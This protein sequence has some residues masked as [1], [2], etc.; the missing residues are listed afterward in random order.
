MGM[1]EQNESMAQQTAE[2]KKRGKRPV[3]GL[4]P[5]YDEFKDSYWMLP[6][7]MI[8]LEESGAIPVMMPLTADEEAVR[9]LAEQ[10]DG[11][12]LTGGHDV[13]PAVYGEEKREVCGTLCRQRDEMEK[14]LLQEVL[15]LDK[16]V[17]GICRGL[18][19]LNGYLGG[20][21]YQDL[22]A[23]YPA[24]GSGEEKQVSHRM[25]PPY[26]GEAHKVT[27]LPDSFLEKILHQKEMGVN[28]C[29]HQGIRKLAPVLKAAAVGPDGLIEAAEMP[30]KRFAAA[31]Q[32]HPEFSFRKSEESRRILAKFV[33]ACCGNAGKCL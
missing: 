25:K 1:T 7:Y 32:W 12:V 17:F 26:D 5:L 23:E 20:T 33:E 19:F 2:E 22:E 30:G 13:D 29:H 3:I 16:P 27:I 4:V 11:F 8:A 31:V 15:R 6:G 28:S 18:Q 21:L 10:L 24:A 14:L 9:Q